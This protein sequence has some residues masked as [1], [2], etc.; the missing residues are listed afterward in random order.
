MSSPWGGS[1][2]RR[3]AGTAPAGSEAHSL[4]GGAQGGD[5][6]VR[7]G[8]QCRWITACARLMPASGRPT[9]STRHEL[10]PRRRRAGRS[11][12]PSPRLLMRGSRRPRA[13]SARLHRLRACARPAETKHQDPERRSS[14]DGHRTTSPSGRRRRSAA[15]PYRKRGLG[16]RERDA[17]RDGGSSS[18]SSGASKASVF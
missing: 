13:M 15:R 11:D 4:L 7:L 14:S 12:R 5:P 3:S 6:A 18:P 16:Q 1:L 2:S 17:W 8:R 10:R 9:G